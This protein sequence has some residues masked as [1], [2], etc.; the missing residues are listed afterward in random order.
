MNGDCGSI[1]MSGSFMLLYNIAAVQQ[2]S[3]WD[4]QQRPRHGHHGSDV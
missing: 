1:E 2:W 3:V 4:R